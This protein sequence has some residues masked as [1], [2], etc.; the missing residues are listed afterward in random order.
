MSASKVPLH[1]SYNSEDDYIEVVFSDSVG[2]I[3]ASEHPAIDQAIDDSGTVV[4]F[5]IKDVSKLAK[6]GFLN[7]RI[8]ST[9][10]SDKAYNVNEIR[11]EHPSAYAKW[12]SDEDQQLAEKFKAGASISVLARSHNRKEGAIR[13]R[14]Q[15]LGLM[16]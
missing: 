16:G 9:T 12:T 15:K 8:E 1:I 3:E 4:G 5:W 6:F 7:V 2:R 11:K 14:L 13:S 10:G